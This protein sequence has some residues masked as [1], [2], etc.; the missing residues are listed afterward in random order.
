MRLHRQS[1][2]LAFSMTRLSRFHGKRVFRPSPGRSGPAA[3][4]ATSIRTTTPPGYLQ[5]GHA[6]WFGMFPIRDRSVR[7]MSCGNGHYVTRSRCG[8]GGSRRP[9]REHKIFIWRN[10][11]VRMQIFG[12]NL[13]PELRAFLITNGGDG[14][15]PQCFII[16]LARRP[17]SEFVYRQNTRSECGN[18]PRD[19]ETLNSLALH[20]K[21]EPKQFQVV[22]TAP[23]DTPRQFWLNSCDYNN[24]G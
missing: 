8:A 13:Q 7:S 15:P 19:R 24:C 2:H 3:C 17:Q 11:T 20:R 23:N 10:P 4:S 22:L 5:L 1:S 9:R 18:C 6:T 14:T 16:A 21:I 12:R